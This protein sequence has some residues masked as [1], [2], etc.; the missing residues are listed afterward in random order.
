MSSDAGA[1]SELP[2]PEPKRRSLREREE[3]KRERREKMLILY[4]PPNEYR[5]NRFPV[6]NRTSVVM[7][8]GMEI[9]TLILAAV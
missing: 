7:K 6:S 9:R 1:A 8:G 2:K 5:V 4:Y 3:E